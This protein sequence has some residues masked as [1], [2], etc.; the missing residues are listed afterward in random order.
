LIELYA[1]FSHRSAAQTTTPNSYRYPNMTMKR[2]IGTTT[3]AAAALAILACGGADQGEENAPASAILAAPSGPRVDFNVPMDGD[4]LSGDSVVVQIG[5]EGV[6]LV[7]AAANRN[8]GEGHLHLF[9]DRDV[10]QGD[11]P[12]PVDPTIVHLG[13]GT[14]TH[15]FR[16]VAPGPHRIIAVFAYNDH[17]PMASVA[18]D[19]INIIVR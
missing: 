11:I 18:R 19:T 10:T 17:T 4:S 3:L 12:I 1:I 8:E 7:P 9:L 2:A 6:R 5:V 16:G 13:T 15:T 14:D